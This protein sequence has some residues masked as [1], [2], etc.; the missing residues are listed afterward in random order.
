MEK[1]HNT[2]GATPTIADLIKLLDPATV[3][4]LTERLH[5]VA[6]SEEEAPEQMLLSFLDESLSAHEEVNEHGM[7]RVQ[8]VS[9][10][11]DEMSQVTAG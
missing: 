7:G 3:N 4:L 1:N 8:M 6:S 5:K 10:I 11:L 2:T 9:A